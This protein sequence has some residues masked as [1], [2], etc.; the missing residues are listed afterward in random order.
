MSQGLNVIGLMSGTSMDGVDAAILTT[1]GEKILGTGPTYST[2]YTD[3]ER[4]QLRQAVDVAQGWLKG[5]PTPGAV[6][7]AAEIVTEKHIRVIDQLTQIAPVEINLIGFHGQTVLHRPEQKWTVQIGYGK[8]LAEES[9]IDVVGDF[10][11]AD[12][13]AGGEG[14][15]FAPLYHKALVEALP[16]AM[17][18]N[19]PVAVLN[20]GGVGNV[21]FIDGEDILAFDTG[22]A[23]G[24]IDD[25]VKSQSG[26]NYDKDGALA[27]RGKVDDRRILKALNNPYFERKP[28]KSLDRLDF[29][30]EMAK[31]LSLED[32]AATLTAF[33]ALCVA[34]AA[35]KLPSE[36]VAWIVCGG[37]R[38]NSTLLR[39]ISAGVS[40]YVYTAED[41]GWRGDHLEAEAFAY[42]AARSVKGLPLSLPTTT[43]VPKPTCGGVLYKA[44]PA[45]DDLT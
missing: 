33:S 44:K 9:G 25:W 23:N 26:A 4:A 20:M 35:R 45:S 16:R 21:T 38:L 32:G 1:D 42:L 2:F 27:A 43:G 12:V 8:V 6:N 39:M 5:A 34:Q 15:P 14:A 10:R 13:A 24:P 36:P 30:M 41:V 40:G 7:R 37:G 22:P 18:P 31:G 17:L 3:E 19:G 28:P 11:K 29:T